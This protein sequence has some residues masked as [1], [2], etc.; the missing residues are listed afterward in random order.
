MAAF[1]VVYNLWQ[2]LD[3]ELLANMNLRR[4]SECG[5]FEIQIPEFANIAGDTVGRHARGDRADAT[6]L[7]DGNKDGGAKHYS[8]SELDD[9]S[10]ALA[11]GLADL[12]VVPGDRIAIH[13]NQSWETA[14]AHLAI[15]KLGA[16]AVLVSVRSGISTV[17]HILKDSGA[18]FVVAAQERWAPFAKQGLSAGLDCLPVIVDPTDSEFEDRSFGALVSQGSANHD[19]VRTRADQPALLI[20]TSG[21]TAKPKGILHSHGVIWS[22]NVSTNWFYNLELSESDL[23]LWTPA[24]WAWVGGLNDTVL[25]AWFHGHPIVANNRLFSAQSALDLMQEHGVTH[26]FM[27]ASGLKMLADIP[28][29]KHRWPRL[30]LRTVCTGGE[31]LPG[32]VFDRLVRNY[33]I[34]CNEFYGLTEVNHMIGTC[35]R[36]RPPKPGSM[37]YETPGHKVCLVNEAGEEVPDGTVG[38][39]V[40][41]K[42]NKTVCRGY[43]GKEDLSDLKLGNW[44]RT[45]DL[46]TRDADGYFYY[47]GRADDL[48]KSSGFRISPAEI[49]DCLLQHSCVADC[50]IVG[51]K[52]ASR[53]QAIRAFVVPNTSAA[54]PDEIATQL[55]QH[56]RARLGPNKVPHEFRFVDALPMTRTGKLSRRILRELE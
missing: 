39:I 35:S 26:V 6:A 37:G 20:Y 11:S 19:A 13:L 27:T 12:G 18:R 43:W 15:Y 49:E 33:D 52:D 34:A 30:K 25:P 29:P 8:Y 31:S 56:V 48:I 1:D 40:T 54:H 4:N 17:H 44:L 2:G 36:V 28:P 16:I 24:D 7:I 55:R 41:T 53:G 14:V 50:G 38:E 32:S 23:V 10:G 22:Y 45:G 42:D 51:R 9:L 5:R 3:P 21:S 46:A 47:K